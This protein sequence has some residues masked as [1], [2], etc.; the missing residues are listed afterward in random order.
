MNL[1]KLRAVVVAISAIVLVTTTSL[2]ASAATN[3][4]RDAQVPLVARGV[5]TNPQQLALLRWYPANQ[6]NIQFPV[7]TSPQEV[8]Y[9][10]SSIWVAGQTGGQVTKLRTSDGTNLECL[11]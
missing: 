10:G 8:A 11:V 4:P 3:E 5:G 6:S 2:F 7:A 9:D 1:H